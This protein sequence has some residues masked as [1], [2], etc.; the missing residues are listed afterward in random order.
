MV[1]AQIGKETL[2]NW[3]N[4]KRLVA[5]IGASLS[6]GAAAA[7]S[8]PPQPSATQASSATKIDLSTP[9]ATLR[10]NK[11]ALKAGD[12]AAM[13]RCYYTADAAEQEAIDAIM[14]CFAAKAQFQQTCIDRFGPAAGEA[15][16]P[17]FNLTIGDKVRQEIHGEQATLYN[18]GGPKPT[19]LRNVN[20]EW[21]F[22]YASLV[23]NNFRDL[24]AMPPQKLV[25]VFK[26]TTDI[27]NTTADEVK[28]GK[29]QGIK[30]AMAKLNERRREEHKKLREMIDSLKANEQKSKQ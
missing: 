16:D 25:E 21:R 17:G 1:R 12:A 23:E 28:A 15:A 22:T 8:P 18:I 2:M 14:N 30:E 19:T 5:L 24:P 20:G 13:K 6:F 4:L 29:Y 27:Y 9:I 7:T 10:S 3:L 11:A 26:P